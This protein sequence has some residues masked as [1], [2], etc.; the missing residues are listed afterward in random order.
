MVITFNSPAYYP[1][2]NGSVEKAN[3]EMK[4]EESFKLVME[5]EAYKGNE[6][7]LFTDNV[8]SCLNHKERRSLGG[9]C[10]CLIFFGSE[11]LNVTR[12]DRKEI[13]EWIVNRKLEIQEKLGQGIKD[14]KATRLAIE[15]WLLLNGHITVVQQESVTGFTGENLS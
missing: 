14:E 3:G 4:T 11:K 6:L 15:T 9:K 8:L 13:Y 10:S 1:K 2:Y 12:R 7:P 5:L